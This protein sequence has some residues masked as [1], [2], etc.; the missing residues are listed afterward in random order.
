MWTGVFFDM[1][2][3]KPDLNQDNA[4]PTSIGLPVLDA[5]AP[6]KKPRSRMGKWR[7]LVLLLVHVLIIIH[8]IHWKVSG[9]SVSP[10]EPSEAIEFS[11]N[12]VVN[13]GLIFFLIALAS[14]MLF[15]RWFCGWACHLVALQDACGWLMKKCGW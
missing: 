6:S 5:A 3:Q 1:T 14:T 10:I 9:S 15:G 13:A 12:G 2:D 7:A 8:V 11:K 4:A